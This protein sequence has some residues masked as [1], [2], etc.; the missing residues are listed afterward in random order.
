MSKTDKPVDIPSD[1]GEIVEDLADKKPK[2]SRA[3]QIMK[4]KL[5]L[6]IIKKLYD[7]E[8]SVITNEDFCG[9]DDIP[10]S[11]L[12]EIEKSIGGMTTL[13]LGDKKN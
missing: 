10:L 12:R 1:I 2:S 4:K 3:T 7:V 11:C 5:Y 13:F 6:E 8:S 9:N